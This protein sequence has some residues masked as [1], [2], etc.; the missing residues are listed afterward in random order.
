MPQTLAQFWASQ[1]PE[2]LGVAKVVGAY[3][4]GLSILP[5]KKTA[6]LVFNF[7]KETSLGEVSARVINQKFADAK[8]STISP[9]TEAMAILGKKVQTDHLLAD[10]HDDARPN[11]Q[12][13]ATRAVAT[14]AD[15]LL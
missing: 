9:Q 10:N 8:P 11:E 13:R 15:D 4:V 2:Q 12:A 1:K 14:R 5:V 3:A 6:D 7:G